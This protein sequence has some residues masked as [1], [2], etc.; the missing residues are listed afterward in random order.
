MVVLKRGIYYVSSAYSYCRIFMYVSFFV[1]ARDDDACLNDVLGGGIVTQICEHKPTE[2]DKLLGIGDYNSSLRMVKLPK[3]FYHV[4]PQEIE[5]GEVCF[6]GSI[7]G[8]G[9]I[10]IIWL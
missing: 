5:V 9:S 4:L 10:H 8:L 6:I 3:N 7:V 1:T 2:P